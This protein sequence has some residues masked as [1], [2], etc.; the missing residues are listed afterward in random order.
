VPA[1]ARGSTVLAALMMPF[2]LLLLAGGAYAGYIVVGGAGVEGG[3]AGMVPAACLPAGWLA[4]WLA[5]VKVGVAV[6]A[7]RAGAA[8]LPWAS[9][10]AAGALTHAAPV[11]VRADVPAREAPGQDPQ[12]KVPQAGLI[13]RSAGGKRR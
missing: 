9:H 13:G 8:R 10:C 1:P 12:Q 7:C 11:P 5:V 2:V 6:P 4:G 3:D